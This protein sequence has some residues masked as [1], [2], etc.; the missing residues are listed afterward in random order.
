[1]TSV[2]DGI[3]VI[4]IANWAAVPSTGVLLSEQG[5]DVIKIEPPSGD[6]MRGLMHQAS[7]DGARE[8]DHPFQFSNRGKRAIAIALDTAE[9]SRLALE[10]IA[11]ADIVLMN[12]LPERR[13]RFGL[14]VDEI[15]SASAT[16]IIGLLTGF[17][18]LGPEADR[19]G[20]DLTSFFAHSGLSASIAGVDGAPP[21]WRAAQGDHVA[22]LALY[23]GVAAALFERERTGM[24]SVVETSLLQSAAWTNGFDLTRAA[25]DGRP[26]KA[27]ARELAASPTTEAY[28]CAD[29]R[30]VQLSLAEPTRGWSIL[31]EVI[32]RS[33]LVDHADY[34]SPALRFVNMAALTE[35]LADSIRALDSAELVAAIRDRGGA[36]ALVMT[37]DEVV[38]N[39]QVRAVGV[40]R[41]VEHRNGL[42]E[43][44]AAPVHVRTD[45]APGLAGSHEPISSYPGPGA[46]TA[47]VLR[48][49]LGYAEADIEALAA[50]GVVAVGTTDKKPR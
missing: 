34:R 15:R 5:A 4:E 28:Q 3:R 13:E 21:R 20:F 41:P 26:T 32:G 7:V 44:V 16:V 17:G 11:T 49:I 31:C 25:A 42:F 9:G 46:H 12:L 14:T 43:V 18:E 2:L 22:G 37:T 30:W 36:C 33:E 50:R 39:P 19:P 23:G 38:A 27:K 35:T 48:E 6:G 45:G 24:G 1:M 10:L 47:D 29:G 40:L 8:V